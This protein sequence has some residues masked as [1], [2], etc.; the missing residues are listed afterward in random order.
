MLTNLLSRTLRHLT[1]VV[2]AGIFAGIFL[3]SSLSAAAE[4]RLYSYLAKDVQDELT[5]FLNKELADEIGMPIVSLAASTGVLHARIMAEAPRINADVIIH[6]D[7]GQIKL[8]KAGL[9]E[10]YPNAPAWKD[11]DAIYKEP[12]GL[13]YNLGTFS[14]VLLANKD[15]ITKKGY[16]MPES[17]FDLL[18]PKWKGEIILPSPVTSGTATLINATALSLFRKEDSGWSFLEHLDK[19]VAQYTKSGNT[20]L[21]AVA[22]G[23]FL[24]GMAS[25]ENVPGMIKEGY[26]LVVAPLR[27]GV[28]AGGNMISIV[29]GT[30]QLEAAKKLVNFAGTK[31]FQH[32]LAQYGYLMAREGMPS[33]LYKTKPKFIELDAAWAADNR[34]RILK[35]WKGKFLKKSESK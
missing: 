25:D 23:E 22:R 17:W 21:N 24:L 10:A 31:K 13:Y 7:W 18:D 9:L 8:A 14:Y 11:I 26:P 19:N 27:E 2:A 32:N 28:G 4:L 33:A 1:A 12:N 30:K 3:F 6:S 15:M 20:P 29:K 35:I 5:A 34:D 16:S